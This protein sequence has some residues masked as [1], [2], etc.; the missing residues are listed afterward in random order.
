MPLFTCMQMGQNV[1]HAPHLE[2]M[3]WWPQSKHTVLVAL[4]TEP[5]TAAAAVKTV[6]A[7]DGNQSNRSSSS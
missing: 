6:R 1:M 4:R 3:H 5:M 2:H 7:S